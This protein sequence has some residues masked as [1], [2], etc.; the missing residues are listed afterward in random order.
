VQQVDLAIGGAAT[1]AGVALAARRRWL[2]ALGLIGAGAIA[3]GAA[4]GKI[5]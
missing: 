5:R 1:A 4:L 3:I 2:P